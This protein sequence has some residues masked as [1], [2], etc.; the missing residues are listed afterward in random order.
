[1]KLDDVTQRLTVPI[2]ALSQASGQDQVW[3]LEKGVLVRRIVITGRRQ[4]ATAGS[5]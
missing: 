5:R 2:S 3:T 1:M 4:V